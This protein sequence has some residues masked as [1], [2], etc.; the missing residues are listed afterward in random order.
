[1]T[2]IIKADNISTVAGTGTITLAAGN[3]LDASAGFVPPAGT[4]VKTYHTKGAFR[5]SISTTTYAAVGLDLT[6]T[7][8]YDNSQFYIQCF[9]LAYDQGGSATLKVESALTRDG[10]NLYELT[11][12]PYHNANLGGFI[13]GS[14]G[15][16]IDSPNVA[17]GTNIVYSW[18]FKKDASGEQSYD[19]SHNDA[20][21]SWITVQEIKA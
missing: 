11:H 5:S 20:D 6:V 8:L 15:A 12:T 3:T 14:T 7:P 19:I 9:W 4:I 16:Y 13:N 1:M 18:K 2:S 21:S 10:I 17:A